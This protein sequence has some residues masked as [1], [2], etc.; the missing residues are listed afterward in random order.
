M[1]TYTLPA[2]TI[3]TAINEG[4]RYILL[5]LPRE[6]DSRRPH[7]H[8]GHR[9]QLATAARG[10][11]NP[12]TRKTFPEMQCVFSGVVTFSADGVVRV[13]SQQFDNASGRLGDRGAGVA[14]MLAAAEQASAGDRAQPAHGF[15][16]AAGFSNYA[17]LWN[18]LRKNDG[19]II[20]RH[21]I[22]WGAPQ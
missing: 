1:A 16:I 7:A 15:A 20:A 8:V 14:R 6:A 12:R 4:R 13:L 19:E 2:A 22:A 17:Q 5:A 11:T 9:L 21:V 18:S 10:G 3:A